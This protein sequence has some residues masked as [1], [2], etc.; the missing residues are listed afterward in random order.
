MFP[1]LG[2]PCQRQRRVTLEPSLVWSI[3]TRSSLSWSIISCKQQQKQQQCKHRQ[4]K[5]QRSQQERNKCSN[6]NVNRNVNNNNVNVIN[7]NTTTQ[8]KTELTDL[9]VWSQW[10]RK[11]SRALWTILCLT[12]DLKNKHT[13]IPFQHFH[14]FMTPYPQ[15]SMF[16]YPIS[17]GFTYSRGGEKCNLQ[18]SGNATY[19]TGVQVYTPVIGP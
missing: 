7:N 5:E 8:K 11:S 2:V 18:K 3:S 16:L 6:E 14:T 1:T 15:T 17:R 10:V 13:P 9:E 19:K 12:T 4:R